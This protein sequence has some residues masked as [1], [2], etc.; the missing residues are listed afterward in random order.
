MF[1]SKDDENGVENDRDAN[2]SDEDSKTVT[3]SLKKDEPVRARSSSPEKS[4]ES[5]YEPSSAN[6][7]DSES[8][9]W[10]N[11]DS[12][13]NCTLFLMFFNHFCC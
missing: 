3:K 5:D 12:L 8:K 10:L 1:E 2:S 9:E 4:D 6:T 13:K 11:K 7:S